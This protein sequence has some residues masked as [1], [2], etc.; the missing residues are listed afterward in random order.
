MKNVLVSLFFV[1]TACSTV[2]AQ[3]Q[4]SGEASAFALKT[5]RSQNQRSLNRGEATFG[6]RLDMFID[7][8]VTDNVFVL[9]NTR[10]VEEDALEIDYAAIRI[11][12]FAGLGF[13]VQMGKFDMPF[14]NLDERRFPSKNFLYGLPLI[15]EYRTSLTNQVATRLD[16]LNG[17]GKGL[18]MRLL[19][20]GIYDLGAML[21]GDAGRLHYAVAGSNG[22]ISSAAY[23]TMNQNSDFNKI[24]RLAYTPM[25]G[26]T[27]GAS[28][29]MGAYLA[30]GGKPLPRDVSSNH[31]QQLIGEADLEFSRD[32]FLLNGEGVYS[33]WT[34]PF[35]N[36]DTKISAI[37]YYAEAKYT[38]FPR[39]YTAAR[40]GG[41]IFS[42]LPIGD[43]NL[44]WDN[45][46]FEVEAGIGYHLDR[47]TILKLVRRETR[48]PEVTGTKDNLTVLQL[49]VSF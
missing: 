16:V 7:A 2:F 5:S 37:G 3:V 39:F 38:W 10:S 43:S 14:G 23:H 22:T 8:K 1:M 24:V 4:L 9:A 36:E 13:N 20:S 18:G 11:V 48:T 6:W 45:N 21:Y 30:D 34:V 19:D 46:V 44:R 26:L 25:M 12:D 32:R 35:E 40:V 42:R 47:N 27:L 41:L 17:R 33:Q 31:Y 29:A 15:Y 28:A 49:A